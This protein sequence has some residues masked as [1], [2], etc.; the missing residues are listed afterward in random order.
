MINYRPRNNLVLVEKIEEE[1]ATKAGI[2][3]V[4]Q[5]ASR[6]I[7]AFKILRVGSS[8]ACQDLKVGDIVLCEDMF[9]R[10]DPDN[11][12]IGLLDQKYI[13]VVEEAKN[14]SN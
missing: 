3:L 11:Q 7:P 14:G 13:H 2:I 9:V 8:E 12:N 6:I 10:I 5:G 1:I 4:N